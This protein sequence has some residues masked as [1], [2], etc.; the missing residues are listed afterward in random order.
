MEFFKDCGTV[1]EVRSSERHVRGY[2]SHVQFEDTHCVDE[3]MKKQGE[4]FMG[5]RI[6][7]DYA[8]MDKVHYNPRGEAEA[9]S[10]RRYRPKSVKPPNGHTL[11]VGDVSIDASEQDL[12]DLFEPA[13]KIEMIC[14]QVNQLRNGQFGHVKFYDTEAVDKAA[15]M[16]GTAVKGVPIRLDFAE[17]KPIAA[18][19]VGK[20]RT[21]PES[22]KPSDC[23]TV[24]VGGL[25]GDATEDMIHSL[26]ERCGEIKEVRLDR[27]KRSGTFFCHVE[28]YESSSVDRAVRLS[29]ERLNCSKIRV[30]FAENRK[31]DPPVPKPGAYPRH[32]GMP[33]LDANGIPLPPM[34]MPPMGMPPGMPPPAGWLG[35]HGHPGMPP[36]PPW[37]APHMRPY[38]PGPLPPHMPPPGMP[39]DGAA[40]GSPRKDAP[41]G[42]WMPAHQGVSKA[43]TA[44]PPAAL[45]D[46]DGDGDSEQGDSGAA[47]EDGEGQLGAPGGPGGA[48][49]ARPPMGPPGYGPPFGGPPP[50]WGGPPPPGYP[51]PPGYPPMRPPPD[52]YGRGPDPYYYDYYGHGG[53]P[54]PRGPP[55]PGAP[56]GG[57]PGAPP[58]APPGYPG[59][60]PP[61]YPPGPD[62]YRR[63]PG[64]PSEYPGPNGPPGVAPARPLA[65]GFDE[66]WRPPGRPGDESIGAPP[67]APPGVPGAQRERSPSVYSD[68]SYSCSY[69][70]SPVEAPP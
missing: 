4:E 67:G 9:P 53:P 3:A 64:P 69:S 48:P 1:T 46:G 34:G 38:P 36:P 30:D 11:W 2:F 44:K 66:F 54:G 61:G 58:G 31:N 57:P 7:I 17:D 32:P 60:A 42:D 10:S 52:F 21:M 5:Q 56:P 43:A 28:Y 51:M 24:W 39:P 62:Y 22:Q 55:P 33:P 13:G 37:M 14:L 63:P 65:P 19:R 23:R 18:Y 20:D 59:E 35:P 70:Y 16:A 49:P 47:R 27:S 41:P 50:G 25:P 68:Y 6:H 15:E 26:F 12:I 29:G 40:P 8:Y 45:T